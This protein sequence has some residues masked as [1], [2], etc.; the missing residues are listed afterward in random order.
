MILLAMVNYASAVLCCKCSGAVCMMCRGRARGKK[1]IS[2]TLE[3]SAALRDAISL[4]EWG[5]ASSGG[6]GS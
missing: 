1:Y 6:T 2:Y 3:S 4:G 5:D